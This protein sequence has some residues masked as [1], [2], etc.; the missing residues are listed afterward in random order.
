MGLYPRMRPRENA[1]SLNE[2]AAGE[3]R[4]D[5]RDYRHDDR[6]SPLR[7]SWVGGRRGQGRAV[8]TSGGGGTGPVVPPVPTSQVLFQ[9]AVTDRE[10]T[11]N[12]VAVVD[13]LTD[14]TAQAAPGSPY[15]LPASGVNMA[16]MAYGVEGGAQVLYIASSG[17]TN[18][19]VKVNTVTGMTLPST[20]GVSVSL[21]GI[22]SLWL[23][24][25]A[26]SSSTRG[27]YYA[28]SLTGRTHIGYQ[29]P[30]RDPWEA[31]ANR[32]RWGMVTGS[33]A[34][35]GLAADNTGTGSGRMFLLDRNGQVF[36]MPAPRNP[37]SFITG[38]QPGGPSASDAAIP[39]TLIATLSELQDPQGVA[40]YIGADAI[41]RLAMVDNRA[42]L[43]RVYT[44]NSATNPTALNATSENITFASLGLGSTVSVRGIA[45]RRPPST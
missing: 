43:I 5:H 31:A 29:F 33:R 9:L 32:A 40:Y 15:T 20:S 11:A 41:S 37:P 22:A 42:D 36:V 25:G 7:S 4:A 28:A 38:Q 18:S 14:A 21:E 1:D 35:R 45:A 3:R 27:L 8:A 39:A 30:Y 34:P 13:V 16:G 23:D 19:V 6:T 26:R 24:D 17:T 10:G 2:R 44:L 12:R